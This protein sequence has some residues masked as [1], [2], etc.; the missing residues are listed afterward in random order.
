MGRCAIEIARGAADRARRTDSSDH[1]P[2]T[3]QPH[4]EDGWMVAGENSLRV[5]T[6]PRAQCKTLTARAYTTFVMSTDALA[7]SAPHAPAKSRRE[8]TPVY[9]L[10]MLALCI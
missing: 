1:Q 3:R 6:R 5:R 9:Q 10:F 4:V 7:S 8:T 2:D